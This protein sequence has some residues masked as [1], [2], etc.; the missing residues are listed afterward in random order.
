MTFFT[1]WPK[2]PTSVVL[3]TAS[4]LQSGQPKPWNQHTCGCH[5]AHPYIHTQGHTTT[6]RCGCTTPHMQCTHNMNTHT[7]THRPKHA[8]RDRGERSPMTLTACGTKAGDATR[9]VRRGCSQGSPKALLFVLAAAG[10]RHRRRGDRNQCSRHGGA[11]VGNLHQGWCSVVRWEGGVP[12]GAR[13][14][15]WRRRCRRVVL[16]QDTEHTAL[17][18]A[19]GSKQLGVK[20]QQRHG[21]DV[22]QQRKGDERARCHEGGEGEGAPSFPTDAT[23]WNP[24]TD[25]HTTRTGCKC[26]ETHL[27]AL[28]PKRKAH[29]VVQTA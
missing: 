15:P 21:T 4:G 20:Q 10:N 29:D 14:G 6:T 26:S 25:R 27:F 13:S 16:V 17:T 2:T 28:L 22:L 1:V 11:A 7:H 23:A 8:P 12:A 18:V 24:Q 19:V 5:H 9:L 3:V